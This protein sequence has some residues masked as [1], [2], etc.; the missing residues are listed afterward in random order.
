MSPAQLLHACRARTAAWV[1]ALRAWLLFER[2]HR[3]LGLLAVTCF[4]CVLSGTWY[5]FAIMGSDLGS[6]PFYEYALWLQPFAA[7]VA[8]PL[9]SIAF[10]ALG[11]RP[12]LPVL[13]LAACG[14]Y[15]ASLAFPAADETFGRS[16]Y[17]Y[18]TGERWEDVDTTNADRLA[19][20][21][22]A[23]AA[24]GV[25]YAASH[26]L[27]PSATRSFA[28]IIGRELS[29]MLG[30]AVALPVAVVGFLLTL[31]S[32]DTWTSLAAVETRTVWLVFVAALLVG[33][34]AGSQAAGANYLQA[35]AT[36]AVIG[37]VS[38]LVFFIAAKILVPP[39]IAGQWLGVDLERVCEEFETQLNDVIQRVEACR[40]PDES[41]DKYSSA[42]DNISRVFAAVTMVGTAAAHK[43]R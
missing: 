36:T 3:L 17:N 14:I 29:S 34:V 6:D 12:R 20:F 26:M 5:I 8:L 25:L 39:S 35:L 4:T 27:F 42:L 30:N 31:L 22:L 32:E 9:M 19:I 10:V 13:P 37:A 2:G 21:L 40:V 43:R 7:I 18:S 28:S 1:T 16:Y 24:V 23:S 15:I 38:L 41:L 11:W 33:A